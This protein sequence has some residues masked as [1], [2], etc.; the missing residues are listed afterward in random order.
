MPFLAMQYGNL[1]NEIRGNDSYIEAKGEDKVKL[2]GTLTEDTFRG[3]LKNSKYYLF[4][5]PFY[6]QISIYY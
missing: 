1:N 6:E 5:D 4:N 2:R 3:E